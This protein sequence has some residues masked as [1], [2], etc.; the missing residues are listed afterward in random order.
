MA[1]DLP[2]LGGPRSGDGLAGLMDRVVHRDRSRDGADRSCRR[3]Q[4]IELLQCCTVGLP[5]IT[6]TGREPRRAGARTA[7]RD[8]TIWAPYH[9]GSIGDP[10]PPTRL[11]TVAGTL[12]RA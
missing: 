10:A 11:V 12:W 3:H 2:V 4:L 7:Q 8:R 6:V 9:S 5:A 1:C